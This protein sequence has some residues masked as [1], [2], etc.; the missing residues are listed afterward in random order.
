MILI[1]QPGAAILTCHRSQSVKIRAIS[2]IC[3]PSRYARQ[4]HTDDSDL[5]DDTDTGNL[6]PPQIQ[7]IPYICQPQQLPRYCDFFNW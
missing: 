3:V 4:G 1:L 2:L 6:N 5:T 7:N